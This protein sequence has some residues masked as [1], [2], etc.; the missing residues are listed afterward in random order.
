MWAKLEAD[1]SG[2]SRKK[3]PRIAKTLHADLAE[4]YQRAG[5]APDQPEQ[6]NVRV[7]R[8]VERLLLRLPPQHRERVE[9]LILNDAEKYVSLL[10]AA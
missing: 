1:E 4:T 6:I 3:I 2:T 5:F 9:Q 10:T 7:G 8:E